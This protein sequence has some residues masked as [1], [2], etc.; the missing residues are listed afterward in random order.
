[1]FSSWF[2]VIEAIVLSH[3]HKF[4]STSIEPMPLS[5]VWNIKPLGIVTSLFV[6]EKAGLFNQ[7]I[8]AKPRR[9]ELLCSFTLYDD[10]YSS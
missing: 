3:A 8:V 2:D 7:V 6:V 9:L 1:M 10:V 5:I 4:T